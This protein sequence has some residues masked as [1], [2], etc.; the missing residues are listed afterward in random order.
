MGVFGPE[1]AHSRPGIIA[2]GC[3]ISP[4]RRRGRGGGSGSV[5][6]MIIVCLIFR[7]MIVL[8]LLIGLILSRSWVV[9]FISLAV[10][11]QTSRRALRIHRPIRVG[12]RPSRPISGWSHLVL[13]IL[14]SLERLPE[15]THVRWGIL[16]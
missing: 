9:L 1:R 4:V 2:I 16:I 13:D 15:A 3:S 10:T 11:H 12:P 8:M 6:V 7:L 14:T 5:G